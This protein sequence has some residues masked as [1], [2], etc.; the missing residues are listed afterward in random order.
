MDLFTL[1]IVQYVN[2][3]D[4]TILLGQCDLCSS[5]FASYLQHYLMDLN[6]TRD[7]GSVWHYG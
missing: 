7:I 4:L 5:D 3:S 6:H 2:M 1:D